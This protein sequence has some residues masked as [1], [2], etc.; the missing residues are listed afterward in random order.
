[1]LSFSIGVIGRRNKRG[2]I[3]SIG[4]RSFRR[5]VQHY[6]ASGERD[7][8]KRQSHPHPC[9]LFG[10][11]VLAQRSEPSTGPFLGQRVRAADRDCI[12][13]LDPSADAAKS[14][15]RNNACLRPKTNEF[16]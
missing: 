11:A 6:A 4:S 2:W 12:A 10:A 16:Y 7:K 15:T 8:G 13:I 9:S 14:L 1:M 5:G 3:R